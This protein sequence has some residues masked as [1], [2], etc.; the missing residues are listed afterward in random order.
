[1]ASEASFL[2]YASYL[3]EKLLAVP[4][5]PKDRTI[6]LGSET[7]IP[8]RYRRDDRIAEQGS[9]EEIYREGRSGVYEFTG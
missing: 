2:S 1:M 8:L 3:C 9:I 5:A 7:S 6:P 4:D